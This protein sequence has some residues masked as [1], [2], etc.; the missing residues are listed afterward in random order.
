VCVWIVS[1][2]KLAHAVRAASLL[3]A[4]IYPGQIPTG[5]SA[6]R[7]VILNWVSP[8][9]VWF[10]PFCLLAFHFPLVA[11]FFSELVL[12]FPLPFRLFGPLRE[13]YKPQLVLR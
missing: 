5:L 10:C 3:S 2:W 6:I 11:S 1:T 4:T 9:L 7:E 12:F 13:L 8:L